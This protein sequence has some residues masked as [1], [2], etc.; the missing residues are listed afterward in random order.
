MALWQHENKGA[1]LGLLS[2]RHCSSAVLIEA[3]RTCRTL[4]FAV[5][6]PGAAYHAAM[7]SGPTPASMTSQ[8]GGPHALSSRGSMGGLA[9]HGGA[10]G[11][12]PHGQLQILTHTHVYAIPRSRAAARHA[13][14]GGLTVSAVSNQHAAAAAF[15]ASAMEHRAGASWSMASAA[16]HAG[17]YM[18]TPAGGLPL[19]VGVT[20]LEPALL[21]VAA[22]LLHPA[23]DR[24]VLLKALKLLASATATVSGSGCAPG[25]WTHAAFRLVPLLSDAVDTCVLEAALGVLVNLT[26][27]AAFTRMFFAAGGSGVGVHAAP[28]AWFFK[29]EP[30][31][32]VTSSCASLNPVRR[33]VLRAFFTAGVTMPL[34]Q[35]LNH[36]C[37]AVAESASCVLSALAEGGLSRDKLCQEEPLLAMLRCLQARTCVTVTIGVL[38]IL[39]RL[40]S[41]RSHVMPSLRSW[42]A[43]PLL[44]R[45][46]ASTRDADCRACCRNLLDALSAGRPRGPASQAAPRTCAAPA[47]GPL[48]A[49]AAVGVAATCIQSQPHGQPAAPASPN[50][51]SDA[52]TSG[53]SPYRP[54]SPLFGRLPHLVSLL[55]GGS[56][57]GVRGA[58]ALADADSVRLCRAI[59]ASMTGAGPGV[60]REREPAMQPESPAAYA[61]ANSAPAEQL[62]G[63]GIGSSSLRFQCAL[64]GAAVHAMQASPPPP[65]AH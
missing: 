36:S 59:S 60:R 26:E 18:P 62:G 65:T 47:P 40:A 57:D 45:L 44:E 41:H 3:L 28:C 61:H 55:G 2:D 49:A 34:L 50:A 31:Q 20:L 5:V 56:E 14:G 51:A 9:A 24:G 37:C 1:L 63:C 27:H 15:A 53:G 48:A 16:Q 46:L 32:L 22:E 35:L 23:T 17:G 6:Q 52:S 39:D 13:L 12:L 42:G 58:Q 10:E 64:G 54:A 25:A 4:C 21:T 7:P 43:V 30:R 33:C 29:Q 38:Y 8:A 11:C 19:L